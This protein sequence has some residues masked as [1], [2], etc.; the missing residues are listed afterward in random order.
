MLSWVEYEKSFIT[1]GPG[2]GL[3]L[4]YALQTRIKWQAHVE[5]EKKKS[6]D[7]NTSPRLAPV[8]FVLYLFLSFSTLF[9]LSW[10]SLIQLQV[11]YGWTFF[12]PNGLK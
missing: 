11:T 10:S 7:Q 8:V 4:K 12:L 9:F 2:P 1:L 3:M 5:E 6:P